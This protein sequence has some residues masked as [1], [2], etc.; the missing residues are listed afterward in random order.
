MASLR[1]RRTTSWPALAAV[2]LVCGPGSLVAALG[3]TGCSRDAAAADADASATESPETETAKAIMAAVDGLRTTAAGGEIGSF[4]PRV[5]LAPMLEHVGPSVVSVHTQGFARRAAFPF[6]GGAFGAPESATPL[7]HGSGFVYSTDGLVVTNHHV[8][9]GAASVKVRMSDGREFA[10]H[11]VG[12]D[13]LTD[14]AL[15]QVDGASGLPAAVMG[16][17][18]AARV[19]DWVVALG[20]PLGLE[21]SASVGI[22]SAKGRGSLGLYRESY[23]DFLQTDAD[24]APGSS[25]GPLFDLQGRV[26]GINT[27]VGP[28]SAPGFA[29]PIDQAKKILP[30]L[31]AHGRVVRGWL[32]A[33]G[34][35]RSDDAST[36]VGATV[37]RVYEGTPAASAGLRE[38]D[39]ITKVDGTAV[40]D[41][42][43]LRARVAELEPG[44]VARLEVTRDGGTLELAATLAERPAADRLDDLRAAPSTGAIGVIP[45]PTPPTPPTARPG[46]LGVQVRPGDRGLEV[47][48][49]EPGSLAEQLGLRTGDVLRSVNGTDIE[50]AP[51]VADALRGGGERL[52][53]D[54]LRDGSVITLSMKIAS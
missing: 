22:V 51:D 23:L 36:T 13:P 29:I 31:Q 6:G 37:G 12:S 14:L 40:K 53:I 7:G 25:G 44:H 1:I 19:G 17:S 9:E 28:G 47:A 52:A 16:D 48:T 45:A 8:V 20:S 26:I 54:V 42:A 27:A 46:R 43:D 11:V 3:A 50:D 34:I 4:D 18:N 39:I 15:V 2:L 38:G 41:F 5:S 32:G 21:H 24:I 30:A 35:E 49:I 33:A 10:A